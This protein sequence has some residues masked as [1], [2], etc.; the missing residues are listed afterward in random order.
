[1]NPTRSDRRPLIAILCFVLAIVCYVGYADSFTT[2]PAHVL[3]AKSRDESAPPPT[4]VPEGGV[5]A[6]PSTPSGY[7]FAA[8]SKKDDA[9]HHGLRHPHGREVP[10]WKLPS[11]TSE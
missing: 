11:P 7:R 6:P 1:M 8:Q 2:S 3:E 5:E 9:L 4:G 10:S